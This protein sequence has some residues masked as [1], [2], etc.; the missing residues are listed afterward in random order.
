VSEFPAL[1]D[2]LVAAGLRRRR[3]RRAAGAAIPALAVTVAAVAAFALSGPAPQQEREETARQPRDPLEQAYAVFRRPQTARDVMPSRGLVA[4][5]VDRSR[6]R[7]LARVGERKLYAVPATLHGKA[8]VCLTIVESRHAG[9]SCVPESQAT[10]GNGVSSSSD[11]AL[12]LPDGAHD[13]RVNFANG[14]RTAPKIENNAVLG[15]DKGFAGASWTDREGV[16]HMS[17]NEFAVKRPAPRFC[18]KALETRVGDAFAAASRAALIEAD[19]LYPNARTARVVVYGE[20]PRKLA[21]CPESVLAQAVVVGV[22]L[23]DE[24]RS[25]RLLLG[26]LAGS[27][28][29]FYKLD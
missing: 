7:L 25:R 8:Q 29:V 21:P 28:R 6:S 10:E 1:R 3:R 23:D 24:K 17:P 22:R 20:G 26:K 12:L 15:V 16:R 9:S 4:D 19:Q 11:Y 2:A 18:P 13:L 14:S 27:W 5:R